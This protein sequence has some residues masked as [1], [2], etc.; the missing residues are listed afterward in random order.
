V[1][2][3]IPFASKD[4][5]WLQRRLTRDIAKT[6]FPTAIYGE[7][8]IPVTKM[9]EAT[10]KMVDPMAWATRD[11]AQSQFNL[12]GQ[13]TP[14]TIDLDLDVRL[15]T[16][17]HSRPK[18]WSDAD[19]ALA[20]EWFYKPFRDEIKAL[21]GDTRNH[22]G[23]ASIGG[24]GH[25]LIRLQN[26]DD[27]SADERKGRLKQ[28]QFTASV[29][30]FTIKLEVRFPTKAAGKLYAVLPGAL[31]T[32]GD[33][34]AFYNTPKGEDRDTSLQEI[35]LPGLCQ[36]VYAAALRMVTA[37]LTQEGER[38]STA[39]L[40]SGV[41][42]REVEDTEREG[43]TFNRDEARRLFETIFAHDTEIK[44]RRR[45][46]EHDFESDAS[47]LPG[48]PAL[49][50]RIGEATAFAIARMLHG[51]DRAPVEAM[52]EQMV[53]IEDDGA[54]V[55][56][57]LERTGGGA[58][59]LYP[60]MTAALLF[61][62]TIGQGRRR[63]KVFKILENLKSRK[64]VDGWLIA[65]GFLQGGFLY[66]TRKG[67]LL[68]QRQSPEDR[69]LINRGPSWATPYVTEEL[70]GRAEAQATLDHMLGWFTSDKAHQAK[71][72][73][74]IAFKVQNPL[75]KPQFALAVS[76]GQGI[77]KSTFF[78][79]VLRTVLG[80]SVKTTSMAALF[81]ERYT[82]SSIMGA[83]LLIV[84]EADEITDF[85]LSKQLHRE[86][87]LDVN[88]K[89]GGKGL[90]WS[91]GIPVYLTNKAEPKLNEPGAIDRTLYI[92]RAPTQYSLGLSAE[93]W[94]AFQKARTAE[95]DAVREK[96][97][98]EDFNLALRQIFQEYPVT[99]VELQDTAMSDSRREDY[100]THDL[101]P[102][103]QT[104][105]A[106]LARGYIHHE[107]P[108]WAFDAPIIKDAFN[109]AFNEL[110][111]KFA[112]KS[113]RPLTNDQISKRLK[114]MLGDDAGVLSARQLA[115]KGRVYWFPYKLGTLRQRFAAVHGV[116]LPDETEAA[117][118]KNENDIEAGKRAWAEW[119]PKGRLTDTANF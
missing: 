80:A 70:P 71:I 105:Q 58:L 77:G 53:F 32:D 30:P 45:V 73:Q 101:S 89:Y 108:N 31:H 110:Y 75:V 9:T 95:T 35:P 43:G 67:Q 8:K 49:G 91:F 88:V 111:L 24:T 16:D 34:V 113:S 2:N 4:N 76:G 84:E 54:K 15:T 20:E 12:L 10:G 14:T 99:Q 86:T 23:R 104:L 22:W 116:A 62:E 68:E 41:L 114:E 87:Q 107:R 97:K 66:L 79:E 81:D 18:T 82:F 78:S 60:R 40:V 26:D 65:P 29:G 44:A 17:L 74:M 38:H 1:P 6:W 51:Y 117:A 47:E 52:R 27:L 102:E 36:A 21:T 48:Y 72:M 112:D 106:M 39:L 46:F 93:A 119:A 118:G 13:L 96:L 55:L 63:T 115:G 109:E 90:Q 50:K 33:H 3:L 11:T 100:R 5:V 25:W 7:G 61:P 85:T 98:G 94:L 59:T 83:S 92:I 42:R 69:S 103:Q 57:T 28:L 37:P 19:K 64:Q 56:N